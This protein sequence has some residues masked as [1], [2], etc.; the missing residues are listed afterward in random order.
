LIPFPWYSVSIIYFYFRISNVEL[1][2]I[3]DLQLKICS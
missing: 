2:L 1:L 3:V